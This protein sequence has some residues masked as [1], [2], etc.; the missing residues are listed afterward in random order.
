MVEAVRGDRLG[1]L[2]VVGEQLAVRSFLIGGVAG[3][4]IVEASVED[5]SPVERL[6]HLG[7]EPTERRRNL[8]LVWGHPRR[9]EDEIEDFE[10]RLLDL[11][12][13]LRAQQCL[14][15]MRV[16]EVD[17][18]ELTIELRQLLLRGVS[19]RAP[20]LA[21][22]IARDPLPAEGDAAWLRMRPAFRRSKLRVLGR[23]V[24]ARM[25]GERVL[26]GDD[27]PPVL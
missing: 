10:P 19:P 2:E 3:E 23:I 22:M 1:L 9:A 20:W 7:R 24:G 27:R 6:G 5:V 12:G 11:P 15:E 17:A 8:L 18:V 13:V 4:E 21:A 16:A 14:A 26:I 25:P